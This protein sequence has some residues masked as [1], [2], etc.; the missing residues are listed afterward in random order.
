MTCCRSRVDS[1]AFGDAL[2]L[3]PTVQAV[4]D[5]NVAKL[6]NAGEPIATTKLFTLVQMPAKH[7]QKMLQDLNQSSALL[8]V[9][10]LWSTLIYGLMLTL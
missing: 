2:H 6:C 8:M 1:V 9:A 4:A 5:Y 7:L 10:G 3:H